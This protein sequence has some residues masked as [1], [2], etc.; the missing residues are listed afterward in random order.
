MEGTIYLAKKHLDNSISSAEKMRTG[1]ALTEDEERSIGTL[2]HEITHNR[3]TDQGGT[4]SPGS[5]SSKTRDYMELANEFVARKTL[6]EFYDALG[7]KMNYPEFMSD[8]TNCGYNDSVLK[9]EKAIIDNGLDEDK[10]LES[11]KKHLFE[12]RYDDQKQGLINALVENSNDK[13]SESD[14]KIIVERCL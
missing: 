8:R 9:Y 3:H 12:G 2:W 10:V 5:A 14:A 6:P 4:D 1:Q 13:I 7:G 11:V